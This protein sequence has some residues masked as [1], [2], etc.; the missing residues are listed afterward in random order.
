[1]E[2]RTLD[3]RAILTSDVSILSE[4]TKISATSDGD[5][6]RSSLGKQIIRNVLFGGLRYALVVPIPFVMTPLILHEIG[7]TG[8][9]TWAVF[10]AI[11]GLTSLADLGL[12]GTLSKFVA[13][14]HATRDFAGLSKALNSGL[15]LFLLIDVAIGMALWIV[16]PVLAKQ[17][18]HGSTVPQHE[19]VL[20]LKLFLIVIAANI[21]TQLFAS[22]TTGLQRLDLTNMI[23]AGNVLLSA[24][25]AGFLLLRGWGLRGLVYGYC[26]SAVLTVVVYMVV[27][28][29]LLPQVVPN[30]LGFDRMEAKKLFSFSL[31]L[32]IT[33][34]AVA[35]HNQ[36]EKVYLGMLVGVSAVGWYDMASDIA[37]KARNGLGVILGPV[38]PAASELHALEDGARMRE[39]F[40]RAHKYLALLGVPVVCYVVTI[41][42]RFVELWV[43]PSLTI[44][45]LPLSILLVVNFFNLATGPGFLIFAGMGDLGPGI[46]SA[47]FGV[48]L[49][50]AL[51]FG[52]IYKFGFAGA[53]L[54]T[55]A[56]IV[57]ASIFFMAVFHHRSGYP[58]WRVLREGYLKAA[59]YS[60]P[61]LLILSRI[62]PARSL[63]WYGMVGVG[64]CF[65]IMYS[66][67]V[68]L[69]GF[70]DDYDWS[71]IESFLP[72]VRYARKRVRIV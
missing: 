71:K 61:I 60:I 9:G 47:T 39:L 42:H 45:A 54:G 55:S 6:T 64:L 66:T 57:L 69:T 46:Q 56:S 44:V 72:P 3:R 12:V 49:N 30:P 26:A 35:V 2:S 34:A 33:Q 68:L 62:F 23:S 63:S 37:L 48:V 13:E 22:V 28:R 19:L 43:G 15:G 31:R 27:I 29:K 21:L 17:L 58:I 50:V 8:Y 4:K 10:L 11:N 20:L 7:V 1:M 38:L 14:Y 5:S 65:C 52:L 24:V 18:F 36:L 16:T 25:F 41:S 53:V 51:S 40:Y 70:F 32:Y 59:A 67:V